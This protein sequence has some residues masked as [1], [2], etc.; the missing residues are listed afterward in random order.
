MAAMTI[1]ARLLAIEET[2][3]RTLPRDSEAI[4]LTEAAAGAAGVA[5]SIEQPDGPNFTDK[6]EAAIAALLTEPSYA[7]AAAAAGISE[8]TLYR[9]LHLPAFRTA[10]RQAR[11]ELVEAGVGR[12]Q[13]A[14]AHA[15]EALV[16]VARHGRRDG[17][18]VRAANALLE[19]AF[20]G[21]TDADRIHGTP[22]AE[23]APS[24]TADVVAILA[25]RL[26]QI[27]QAEL[28]AADKARLTAVLADSLLRAIGVDVIDKRLEA[29]H[30]ILAG[31]QETT[32]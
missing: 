16:A 3:G 2:A 23:P 27:D 17:D 31:R 5:C 8:G 4:A 20:R 30:A 11:R 22:A 29:M 28:P 10:F 18:R 7:R 15:V 24:G 14:T 1:R 6:Q 26:R 13:A 12:L 21:L 19:H 9:W 32:P 25:A